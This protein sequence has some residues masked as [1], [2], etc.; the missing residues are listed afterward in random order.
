[1]EY[2]PQSKNIGTQMCPIE[3]CSFLNIRKMESSEWRIGGSGRP[4]FDRV[5]RI[6]RVAAKGHLSEYADGSGAV[7]ARASK[8]RRLVVG[9]DTSARA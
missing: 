5:R 2:I 6:C 9:L 4:G 8:F 1:M 7:Y 3:R